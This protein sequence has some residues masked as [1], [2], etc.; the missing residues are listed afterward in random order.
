LSAL[1]NLGM[2]WTWQEIERHWL[3][4]ARVAYSATEAVDAF[5]LVER[6]LGAI[7]MREH[8]TSGGAEVWG[9][10]PTASIVD[11]GRR[12]ASLEA[13]AGADDLVRRIQRKDVS[14]LA[15]LTAIYLLRGGRPSLQVEL[16]PEV[17]VDGGPRRPDLRLR[18]GVDELWTY[19]EVT[20]PDTSD[21]EQRV[22]TVM[23][24]VTA[25]IGEVHKSFAL[26][27]FLRREPTDAEVDA[28][29]NRVGAVCSSDGSARVELPDGLGLLLLNQNQPGAM[30]LDDHGEPNVPRLG[31]AQVIGGGTE[32]HR[33]IAVRMAYAD[34]RA[35]R[36]FGR[37]ARQLPT[38]APGLM[39]IGMGRAPGGFK[40]WQ[41]LIQRRLQP[42]IN[43]RVSAVCLLSGGSVD[44]P[45]GEKILNEIKLL[46]NPHAAF[47]LPQ[48]L[49]EALTQAGEEYRRSTAPKTG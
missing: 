11:M 5:N 7:W 31:Q 6:T 42:K 29:V 36:F 1:H 28:L 20:Q 4:G 9:S 30:V 25:P 49:A 41:P 27:V 26:E 46:T 35:E 21:A 48:W 8:N 2:I 43:T 15:E 47:L 16:G 10:G 37:E 3:R 38:D 12:L 40:V 14:A 18:Q 23:T 44:T 22:R 19:V 45:D 39:M 24:R 34:D 33:H 32:P 13:L 17:I